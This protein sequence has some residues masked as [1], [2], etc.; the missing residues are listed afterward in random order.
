METKREEE[1]GD[2]L[3]S[4]SDNLCFG[5]GFSLQDGIIS[6]FWWVTEVIGYYYAHGY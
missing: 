5:T 3:G 1:V 6:V 4:A 2:I